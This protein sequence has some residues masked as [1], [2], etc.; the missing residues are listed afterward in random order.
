MM[1]PKALQNRWWLV[2]ASAVGLTVG[3]SSIVF[4]S[5]S[6]FVK[7]V[8]RELGWS[9]SDFS[10]ALT[11]IGII[12]VF[13]SP[14]FGTLIDR[15]RIRR[16]ALPLV[17]ILGLAVA[18]MSLMTPSLLLMYG[19]FA[20]CG[21]VSPAQSPLLYSKVIALWFDRNLGIALGIATAGLGF[22]TLLMPLEA[23][24]LIDHFGWRRA[25]LGM[26]LTNFVFAFTA[27]A[28]FIRE[29]PDHR[30]RALVEAGQVEPLPGVPLHTAVR[31]WTFWALAIAF[32]LGGI[33]NGALVHV[34]ALLTD[35]GVPAATAARVLASSGPAVILGRLAGGYLLDRSKRPLLPSVFVL[36]PA[37]GCAVL[38]SGWG[39]IAPTV[40]VVLCG[41]GVGVE[42]D[43]LGYFVRRYF[44]PGS[45]GRVFGFI[46][47][48]FAVGASLGPLLMARSYD[49][50]HSYDTALLA[51]TAGMIV[52]T[53]LIASLGPYVFPRAKEQP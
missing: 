5:F 8:T 11:L 23:Q 12:A 1:L 44:G 25:Y 9:R 16:V 2:F 51:N 35:R 19:I 26:G 15:Y 6:V 40:A 36:L 17:A 48:G 18:S 49:I 27:V 46:W 43:M 4:N 29:P 32:T 14:L 50:T 20:V 39:G 33:A 3:M 22:G 52:A 7:P 13:V 38:A 21:L 34:V 37:V 41:F 30:S 45:V 42:V 10:F 53:L 47:P 28:L 24:Y 31:S